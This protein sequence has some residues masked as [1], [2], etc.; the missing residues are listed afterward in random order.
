MI[1]DILDNKSALAEEWAAAEADKN[2][3]D[4]RALREQKFATAYEEMLDGIRI[5]SIREKLLP[6]ELND[7]DGQ[8]LSDCRKYIKQGMK[9]YEKQQVSAKDKLTTNICNINKKIKKEIKCHAKE[10]EKSQD[11]ISMQRE[12]EAVRAISPGTVPGELVMRIMKAGKETATLKD[13]KDNLAAVAEAQKCLAE[14]PMEK[15]QHDLLTRL[16]LGQGHISLL[17]LK[18]KELEWLKSSNIAAKVKLSYERF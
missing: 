3:L 11:Y 4:E 5:M 12:L 18:P 1:I 13:L 9:A 16:T 14:T 17:D 15:W 6:L 8:T 7:L 2:R 10:F